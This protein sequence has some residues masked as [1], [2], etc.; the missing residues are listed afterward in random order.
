MIRL[1][2]GA[3]KKILKELRKLSVKHTRD[4][5]GLFIAEGE[6][7]VRSVPSDI[8]KYYVFSEK[9]GR[10]FTD[11]FD[12]GDFPAYFVEDGFF[13]EICDTVNPQG[14]ACV[15]RRKEY[16]LSDLFKSKPEFI[17][18]GEEI[19]DP[20]NLGT[21]IRTADA[22][23]AGGVILT[24][25]SAD[26]YSPKVLRSAMG[27]VFNIPVYTGADMEE[28]L[29]VLKKKTFLFWLHILGEKQPP[30]KWI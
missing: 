13:R 16:E 20:G 8:I 24:K 10:D 23:G 18:V 27:S 28:I 7:L 30:I 15:C 14:A 5:T 6:R 9:C 1:I 26:I 21:I 4:K 25:G 12:T 2:T 17:V 19:Q 3:P 29:K 22:G 11:R